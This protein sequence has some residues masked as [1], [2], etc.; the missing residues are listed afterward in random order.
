METKTKTGIC[1]E[2]IQTKRLLLLKW[3]KRK[4]PEE[5]DEETKKK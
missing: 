3:K 2:K 4:Q 5:V 1:G